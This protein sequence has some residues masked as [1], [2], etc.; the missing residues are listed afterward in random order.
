MHRRREVDGVEAL[1]PVA[2]LRVGEHP[3]NLLDEGGFRV[4][5][6]KGRVHL[7]E[8][9]LDVVARLSRTRAADH[10]DVEVS[11]VLQVEALAPRGHGVVLGEKDVAVGLIGVSERLALLAGAPAG[12]ARLLARAVVADEHGVAQPHQPYRYGE[13]AAVEQGHRLEREGQR[14]RRDVRGQR[15]HD[16]HVAVEEGAVVQLQQHAET[17]WYLKNISTSA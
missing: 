6:E 4:R 17:H 3:A 14:G 1:E 2:V 13:P 12:A 8:V 9:G 7:H 5:H 11:V 16:L 15:G 10:H